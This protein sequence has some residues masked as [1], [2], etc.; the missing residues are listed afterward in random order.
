MNSPGTGPGRKTS[1][2]GRSHVHHMQA[3]KK[4]SIPHNAYIHWLRSF[5]D[6]SGDREGSVS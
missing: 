1:K 5:D 6:P 4:F 2:A 3:E